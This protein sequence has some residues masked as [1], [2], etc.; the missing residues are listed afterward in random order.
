MTKVRAFVFRHRYY[1]GILGLLLLYAWAVV[2]LFSVWRVPSVL[3]QFYALDY[4]MGFASYLLTGAVYRLFFQTVSPTAIDAFHT[5]LLIL[6]FS[7]LA[8]FCEKVILRAAAEDRRAVCVVVFLF[9]TGPFTFAPYVID[10]GMQEIF[11]LFLAVLFFVCLS[12]PSLYLFS[13]PLCAAALLVNYAAVISCAPF[14][15]VLLLYRLS[16]E[17]RKSSKTILLVSFCLSVAVSIGLFFYLAF[18][19]KRNMVFSFEDFNALLR[20]RGAT[21]VY[22]VDSLLY[23]AYESGYSEQVAAFKLNCPFYVQGTDLT[24]VQ[25]LMNRILDRVGIVLTSLR[26]RNPLQIAVPMLAGLPVTALIFRFCFAELK[27]KA[28]SRLR[29]FVFFCAPALFV[30]GIAA[31]WTV[32]FDYFKWICFLFVPL[33]SFF[34]YVLY[35]ESAHA[36]AF[37]KRAVSAFSFPHVLIYCAVYSLCV[38][39]AYV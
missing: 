33:F 4:G 39:S 36:A 29:R 15:C 18:Y 35:Q 30:L 37:I 7:A 14:F 25:I 5:V 23:D 34:L 17:T 11:W 24:G 22:Y 2:G 13:V 1:F 3:Y 27:N 28:N 8:L 10:L 31:A 19:G 9:L 32:S 20:A 21:E 16:M 26:D 6:F 38:Y 12:R